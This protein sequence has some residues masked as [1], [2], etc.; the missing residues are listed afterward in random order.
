MADYPYIYGWKNN[1]KRATLYG[2]RCQVLARL[3]FNSAIIEFENGQ[4][5]VVSRNALRKVKNE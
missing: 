3:A 4:R 1:E 5:E 2:R